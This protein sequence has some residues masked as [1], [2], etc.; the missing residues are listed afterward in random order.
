MDRAD[1]QMSHR[2]ARESEVI[3][4]NIISRY[5]AQASS[6]LLGSPESSAALY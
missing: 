5:I 1:Q 2:L 4:A 6:T 3:R